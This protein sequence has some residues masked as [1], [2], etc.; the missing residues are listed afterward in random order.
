MITFEMERI[1]EAHRHE[2]QSFFKAH[3]GDEEMVYSHGSYIC[4]ELDGFVALSDESIV[5]AVT[6]QDDQN[7]KEREIISLNSLIERQGIGNRF[8]EMV[9]SDAHANR[10]KTVWL[11]MTNDNVHALSFYQKRGYQLI[12]IRRHAVNEARQIKPDIPLRADNGIYIQ[13]EWVLRKEMQGEQ[14]EAR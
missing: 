10:I 4:H 1:E 8:M 2:L 9:E 5:G 7:T 6:F 3:W 13:D 14:A 11:V 12:N